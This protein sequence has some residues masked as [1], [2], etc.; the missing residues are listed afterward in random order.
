MLLWEWHIG[1]LL[2]ISCGVICSR[3][4]MDV[5]ILLAHL[6]FTSQIWY[7]FK[8]RTDHYFSLYQTII[9]LLES[10]CLLRA[11]LLFLLTSYNLSMYIIGIICISTLYTTALK[12]LK[13]VRFF[14][15]IFWGKILKTFSWA[16][17]MPDGPE[18]TSVGLASVFMDENYKYIFPCDFSCRGTHN[19]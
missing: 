16:Q 7:G 5:S 14:I 2:H 3:P 8:P 11:C 19:Y 13:F 17:Y 10:V 6:I 4:L 1:N 9:F 12:A 15:F 18:T